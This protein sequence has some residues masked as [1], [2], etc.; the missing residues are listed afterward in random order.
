MES[1]DSRESQSKIDVYLVGGINDIR[2]FPQRYYSDKF[3]S[4]HERKKSNSF[5][6]H[7]RLNY[8]YVVTYSIVRWQ[9]PV[10]SNLTKDRMYNARL[11]SGPDEKIA[12]NYYYHAIVFI[13]WLRNC[14]V[15]INC[16]KIYAGFDKF[17][18]IVTLVYPFPFREINLINLY[19]A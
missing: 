12:T 9:F 4:T 18:P 1:A 16:F 6:K 5:Y 19:L 3:S 17:V 14:E 15:T 13:T 8:L 7:L 11:S 10:I 2:H